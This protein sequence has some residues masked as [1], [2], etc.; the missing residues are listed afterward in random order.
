MSGDGSWL[1][2]RAQWRIV[3]KDAKIYVS[4]TQTPLGAAILRQLEQQGYG[5]IV[6]G[7]GKEPDPTDAAQ[8][9]AFFAKNTPH[10]VFVTAGKSGGIAANQKYPAGLMMDNL[11]VACHVVHSAYYHG[12]EKLLYLASSCSY[13]R[14]CPQPMAVDALLSGPLEPTNEAYAIAKIAGIKLCQAYNQQ[15]GTNFVSCIPTNTFGPGDDLD[16]EDSHVIAALMRKMHEAKLTGAEY[17]EIWGTGAPRREFI[18]V[19]DLADACIFI[20]RNYHELGPVN[21]GSGAVLSIAELAMLIKEVVAYRGE[22]RFDTGRPDGMPMKVL[23]SNELL[24]M[25]W[26]PLTSLS[27]ALAQM[28]TWYLK[29]GPGHP[30]TWR[31][32]EAV[33]LSSPGKG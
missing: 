17:V 2:Y 27:D 28:Y 15:Y 14:Q 32:D 24:K 26:R 6:G 4:G 16:L 9:D 7:P 30:E 12:V 23:D 21:I 8:L 10:Y 20:M 1:R 5:N 31:P 18:F 11:L 13:P 33:I 29:F 22:V 3:D 19:D 25:G